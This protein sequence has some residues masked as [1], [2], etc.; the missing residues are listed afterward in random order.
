MW[1]KKY[2]NLIL[3][4]FITL[5]VGNAYCFTILIDP[6]HGGGVLGAKGTYK[7]GKK[8]ITVYEKDLALELAKEI[9]EALKHKY[10]TYLTRS[11]D[12]A[13]TLDARAELAEKV[14]ADLLI[15]VHFNSF[16]SAKSSGF[17]TYYLDNHKNAAVKKVEQIE[18]KNLKGEDLVINQI[19]ID[20]V[21]QKTAKTSRGFAQLIHA[22]LQKNIQKKFKIKNRK[23]RP[24]LFYVLALSKRP[25]VLLEAGF[26]SNPKE[27]KKMVT[28]KFQKAYAESVAK[29]IENYLRKYKP[30]KLSIF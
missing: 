15:S 14:K 22:Q 13:V 25:G 17:E 1:L 6:G 18:N 24:G 19:L 29:A 27:L 7:I 3:F 26:I 4:I 9:Y 2:T 10:S 20:L 21:I 30:S 28:K 8:T 23:V 5:S 16:R 12:H 11:F